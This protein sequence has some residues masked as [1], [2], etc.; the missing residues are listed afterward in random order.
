LNNG[1]LSG[2][3]AFLRYGVPLR[4]SLQGTSYTQPAINL[5]GVSSLPATASLPA[6]IIG[7]LLFGGSGKSALSLILNNRPESLGLQVL[8]LHYIHVDHKLFLLK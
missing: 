8:K 4:I 5:G 7:G 3:G 1:D 6:G 2:C